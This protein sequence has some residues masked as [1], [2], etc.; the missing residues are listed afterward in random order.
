MQSLS[1]RCEPVHVDGH[2]PAGDW[3]QLLINESP[4]VILSRKGCFMCHVMRRLLASI[5][6]HP[7]VIELDEAEAAVTAPPLPVLFVGGNLVGGLERLVGLHLSGALEPR[8]VQA[9][10]IRSF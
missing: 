10:A 5:G 1:L 7:S 2:E 4:I 9:G 8:L 3:I 6:A